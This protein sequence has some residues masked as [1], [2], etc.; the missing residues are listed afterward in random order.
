[1][2]LKTLPRGH[3]QGLVTVLLAQTIV[4]QVYVRRHHPAR[5]TAADHEHV[6]LALLSHITVVL[7]I[8][9]VKLQELLI[10]RIKHLR[11]RIMQRHPNIT[12]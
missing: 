12:G 3:P 2:K 9:P 11:F 5:N 8:N 7:L 1:M 10:I 6:L 4:G